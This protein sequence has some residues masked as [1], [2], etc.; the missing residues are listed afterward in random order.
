MMETIKQY[1]ERLAKVRAADAESFRAGGW[2]IMAALMDRY[3]DE[4]EKA[5]AGIAD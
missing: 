3:A 1:H 4:H 5:A 2:H